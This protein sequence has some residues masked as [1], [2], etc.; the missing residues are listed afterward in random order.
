LEV[1]VKITGSATVFGVTDV[2]SA[3]RFYVGVLGFKEEFRFG[4]YAG[5]EREG[6]MIHLSQKDNP[7]T[8]MPG[9]GT[10]Y[11]FCDEVDGFFAQVVGKGARVD[12]EP[13]DYPYGM[14]DFILRDVDGNR[15]SF[16]AAVK[17]G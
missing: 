8:P 6:C 16:G 17:K 13:E 14:R 2:D 9:L 7:N 3:V 5:V 4:K 12:G 11:I 15:L 1:N 10:V